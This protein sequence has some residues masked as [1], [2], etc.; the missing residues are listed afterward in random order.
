[1]IS[2]VSPYI[3]STKRRDDGI[4]LEIQ[5]YARGMASIKYSEGTQNNP[6]QFITLSKNERAFNLPLIEGK[7]L[8]DVNS[9][10]VVVNHV[11]SYTDKR[12]VLNQL[13]LIQDEYLLNAGK[14][15]FSDDITQDIQ[16][17][18]FATTERT[19]FNDI[20]RHQGSVTKLVDLA[21]TYIKNNILVI[22]DDI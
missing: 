7:R 15:L 10:E 11:I 18:I 17:K 3:Y 1:M 5:E 21:E 12:T 13:E 6:F 16:F 22:I 2:Y 19:T 9:N 20:Q 4:E 14:V 8:L